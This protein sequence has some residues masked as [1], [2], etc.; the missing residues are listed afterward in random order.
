MVPQK[1]SG[2]TI[3]ELLI[4]IVV[5]GILAAIVIVAFNGVQQQARNAQTVSIIKSYQK[6][7]MRYAIE[8]QEYPVAGRACLGEDYPDSGDFIT[9]N[10][11]NCFRSNSSGTVNAGFNNNIRPYMGGSLP[12][13]SNVIIGAGTNPS[14]T[15]RGAILATN[16]TTM[17]IDGVTHPWV[18]IYTLEG[19]TKCPVGP[20]LNL[21]GWPNL[22]SG[23]PSSGFSQLINSGT[24]GVECWIAMPDPSKM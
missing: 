3:V 11:R 2:F 7:L 17:T 8:H 12:T 10:S 21:S 24:I 6:A 20:I 13:P 18:L 23:E 5:I 22:S 16:F 15:S 19:Q 9:S 14:W 4:V 1:S